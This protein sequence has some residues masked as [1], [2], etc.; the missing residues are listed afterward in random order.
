MTG[1]ASIVQFPHP[2]AEHVPRSDVMPWNTGPHRRKFLRSHGS[3]VSPNGAITFEGQLA[4]W[5]EWEPPSIIERRW[6]DK[7]GLPTVLHAPCWEDPGPL[8]KRQNTDPWVFGSNFLYSNCKQLNP[9]GTASALQR[10]QSGSLILF[11]SVRGDEFVL[12][13]VFAVADPITRYRP[14]DGLV[15][16]SEAFTA[17]TLDSLTTT[18]ARYSRATFTLFRGAT[19]REPVNGMFSFVPCRPWVSDDPPVRASGRT[20]PGDHQSSQPS[21]AFRRQN[22]L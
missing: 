22:P 10:L 6:A 7:R 5:G 18:S 13:T 1:D 2:G 9:T 17:C 4:F 16:R 11:G 12:D 15:G 3:I 19:P 14:E 21:V 20:T 8:G